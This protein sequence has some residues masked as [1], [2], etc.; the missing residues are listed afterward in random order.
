MI[1]TDEGKQEFLKTKFHQYF[2]INLAGFLVE[3]NITQFVN[4]VLPLSKINE[5]YN[6]EGLRKFFNDDF[7]NVIFSSADN[8][9]I[10]RYEIYQNVYFIRLDPFSY[11]L[12]MHIVPKKY[13]ASD[14][15]TN[16]SLLFFKDKKQTISG[17]N[18]FCTEEY[19]R[20][21]DKNNINLYYKENEVI[22]TAEGMYK[23]DI[24]EHTRNMSNLQINLGYSY[25]D[26][27]PSDLL[28]HYT[29]ILDE[30]DEFGEPIEN[31]TEWNLTLI[32]AN[33][34]NRSMY[35]NVAKM[36]KLS[37]NQVVWPTDYDP[38]EGIGFDNGHSINEVY[39]KT[40][41][42]FN[43]DLYIEEDSQYINVDWREE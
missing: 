13:D 7:N 2:D 23:F 34:D 22:E 11:S 18:F 19:E 6:L 25:N 4:F 15:K 28:T 39:H 41:K 40:I 17:E 32:D 21:E 5:V 3:D 29:G 8:K 27:N 33:Y 37:N 38:Y 42:Y 12:R 43:D 14:E 31:K 20:K 1:L 10:Y 9:H 35:T 16:N 24:R 26:S 30:S 36:M